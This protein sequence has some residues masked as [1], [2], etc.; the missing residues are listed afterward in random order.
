MQTSADPAQDPAPEAGGWRDDLHRHSRGLI[1][2]SAWIVVVLLLLLW[3][4]IGYRSLVEWL[5]E[6]EFATFGRYYASLTVAI[7]VLLLGLPVAALVGWFRRRRRLRG[8]AKLGE[9]DA[10]VLLARATVSAGRSATFFFALATLSGLG[11]AG[12]F[13]S[14]LWLPSDAGRAR[15]VGSVADAAQGQGPAAFVRP[16]RIGRV[17]RIE[18]NVGLVQ[19][20]MYVAPVRLAGQPDDLTL[21]TTVDATSLE[22][23]RFVPIR[24]GVL[25]RQGLPGELVNL[26]R[27]AGIP[28]PDRSYLLMR[29]GA[30]VRW[31]PLVLGVQ[32]ALLSLISVIAALL[33]RRQAG[34]LKRIGERARF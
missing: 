9:T 3:W 26:Y 22:P 5:A 16:V 17:A 20:V 1:G 25:V 15:V 30:T 18:E 19:R 24:T 4:A 32:V 12:V 8:D 11:A 7:V 14:M 31:R 2:A 34:R 6:W 13:I 33:F 28:V 10:G 29:D 27:G 21:L 23:P